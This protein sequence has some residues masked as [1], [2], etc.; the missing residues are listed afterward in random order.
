MKIK[1]QYGVVIDFGIAVN[2]MDDEI[3]EE[4]VWKGKCETNQ[5][6]FDEYCKRHKEKYSE[7]FELDKANPC[8]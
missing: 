4:I 2:Y 1:N 5:D 7:E 6:F 8:Y 3:R